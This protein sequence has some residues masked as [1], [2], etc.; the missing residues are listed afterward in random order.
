MRLQSNETDFLHTN[1]KTKRG[2]EKHTFQI[3]KSP[4][5]DKTLEKETIQEK[6]QLPNLTPPA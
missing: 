4:N 2:G 1:A 6:T 3:H 5:G